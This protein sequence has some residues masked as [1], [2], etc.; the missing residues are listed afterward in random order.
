MIKVILDTCILDYL[1]KDECSSTMQN[2]VE[3]LTNE[4]SLEKMFISEFT[5]FE[6]LRGARKIRMITDYIG[7]YRKIRISDEVLT[8]AA[9]LYSACQKVNNRKIGSD[10]DCIIG[11]TSFFTMGSFILSADGDG[12]PRPFFTEV[13]RGE[14]FY[15]RHGEQKRHDIFL[16]KPNWKALTEGLKDHRKRV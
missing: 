11:A 7:R 16:L 4:H 8:L 12:F 3:I 15:E 10:G 6:L 14:I 13:D 9:F 5:K 1:A 2:C